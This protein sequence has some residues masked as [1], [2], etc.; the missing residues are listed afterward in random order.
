LGEFLVKNV[1]EFQEK[2]RTCNNLIGSARIKKKFE[3]CIL[4]VIPLFQHHKNKHM[5]SNA[6]PKTSM[7]SHS[8]TQQCA[9]S[10]VNIKESLTMVQKVQE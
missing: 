3:L 1:D 7:C 5:L 4:D 8:H 9:E 2:H 10:I 6:C